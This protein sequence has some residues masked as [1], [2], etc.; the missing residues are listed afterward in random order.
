[1][2][3]DG[4]QRISQDVLAVGDGVVCVLQVPQE[5]EAIAPY[6]VRLG[7]G[8]EEGGMYGH[9]GHGASVFS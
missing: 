9:Y 2:R 1:M 6:T 4:A 7:G 3:Q 5:F 8:A